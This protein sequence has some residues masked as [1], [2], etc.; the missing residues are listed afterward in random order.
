M[1]SESVDGY[2]ESMFRFE[3]LHPSW[4]D[5]CARYLR[6]IFGDTIE[7]SVFLD[8]AFGRG[9]WSLAALRAG[10][11]RVVAVDSAAG[12]VRRFTEYC[13]ANNVSAVEIVHGD[14]LEESLQVQ[15]DVLWVYGIL[16]HIAE[17]QVFV[18]R[19]SALRRDRHSLALFYAY[20]RHS[21]RQVIVEGARRCVIYESESDFEQESYLF[22]PRARLRAR[23]DLTA[24]LVSW[25]TAA[26]LGTLVESNGWRVQRQPPD[27]RDWLSQISS[28]EFSPHHLLCGSEGSR[29]EHL[30]EPQRSDAYDLLVIAD[31]ARAVIDRASLRQRR[32]IA[33]GLFNSHFCALSP[34]GRA[35]LAVRED[36]LYLLHAAVRLE[37]SKADFDNRTGD[38]Y[39]AALAAIA[40]TPRNELLQHS[41][42]SPLAR[43]LVNNTVRI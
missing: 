34:D 3:R 29:L 21:F 18:S 31:M 16:H 27:F 22:S 42:Q 40:D 7:G 39:V 43:F 6:H 33:V 35:E 38:Y 2:A 32:K 1:T 19:L 28:Q 10:A 26:D 23:D 37:M 41:R 5:S 8:Y 24:P 36:F 12:N 14:V 20:D 4:I 30:I 17:A 25:Y 9:N 11:R 15:A 13:R